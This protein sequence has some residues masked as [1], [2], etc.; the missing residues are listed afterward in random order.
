[1]SS[2]DMKQSMLHPENR[3]LEI[4]TVDDYN[5]FS[6]SIE[7]LMGNKVDTRRE[8]L[9]DNVDFSVLNR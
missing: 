1:M 9:F 7:M 2:E 6:D 3:H 4:L 8:F 5:S